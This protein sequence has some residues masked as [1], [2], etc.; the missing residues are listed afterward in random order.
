MAQRVIFRVTSP[1]GYS[2]ELTRNRWR[3]IIRFKHPAIESY[4]DEAKQCVLQPVLIRA[5]AKDPDVHL[6]YLPLKSGKHICVVVSPGNSDGRFVVT[7][8]LTNRIKQG[9][10]LWKK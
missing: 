6:H 8:Y 5:S 2:V 10:E 9:D 7:A 1:L 3:E 4:Q